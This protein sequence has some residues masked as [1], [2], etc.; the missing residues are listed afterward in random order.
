MGMLF[1]SYQL[2]ADGS[3]L[4]DSESASKG[5]RGQSG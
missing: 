5:S 2:L 1:S 4:A 3:A